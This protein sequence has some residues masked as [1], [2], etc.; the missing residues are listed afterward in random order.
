MRF[1]FVFMISMF[2]LCWEEVARVVP[3]GGRAL[4][5]GGGGGSVIITR[6]GSV[7][8]ILNTFG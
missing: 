1:D 5:W 2:G 4:D 3:R 7:K 8:S 6:Y